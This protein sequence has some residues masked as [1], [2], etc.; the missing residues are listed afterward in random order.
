MSPFLP[1][2]TPNVLC[3]YPVIKSGK[4][5]GELDKDPEEERNVIISGLVGLP[6]AVFTPPSS[7]S[8]D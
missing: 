2:F 6:H 5:G 1:G 7:F 4:V 8:V 3:E